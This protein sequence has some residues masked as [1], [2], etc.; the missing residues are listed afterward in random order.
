MPNH[1][2]NN[3]KI[4]G[5]AEDVK[6][7][8]ETIVKPLEV[9]DYEGNVSIETRFSFEHIIPMPKT[10]H[11]E[12][13]TRTDDGIKLV[14]G[15]E[16]EREEVISKYKKWYGDGKGKNVLDI[17]DKRNKLDIE[18]NEVMELGKIALENIKLYGH[19]DWY[20]WSIA[21][22]G[23]KWDAYEVSYEYGGGTEL[24]LNFQTAWSTP[25][26]IFDKLTEMFP[27][28][29]I[30]IEYADEDWGNNCGTMLYVNG[31]M[32]SWEDGDMDFAMGLWGYTPEEIEEEK[33][34]WAE[35]DA[36]EDEED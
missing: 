36:E 3:V 13:G 5:N 34:R 19:K 30:Y 21:N 33:R 24:E 35:E 12:S 17:A 8:F 9:K 22:W 20:D 18:L 29:S 6:K 31:E 25:K 23:T 15:T 28:L 26:P 2:I 27:E 4:S 14:S 7:C 16:K 11:I 1:I 32:T 10:L